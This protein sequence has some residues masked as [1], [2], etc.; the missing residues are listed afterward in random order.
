MKF[1]NNKVKKIIKWWLI[2][3]LSAIILFVLF[4]LIASNITVNNQNTGDKTELIYIQDNGRHID[5]ITKENDSCYIGYGWG[6]EVFY[7]NV[8]TW[9]DLTVKVVCQA[10]F[11]KPKSLM[12]I[13]YHKNINNN[14]KE[15]KV[16]KE[17]LSNLNDIIASS[18]KTIDG[19]LVFRSKGYTDSDV[20]YEANG[21]YTIFKTCN[22]WANNV[23]KKSG[24]KALYW[25]PFSSDISE[26]YK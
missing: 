26:L 25:T 12:H 20:F 5:I 15:I 13:T 11:T 10:L 14:W 16:T 22:T 18:F 3:K 17:Q 6:S 23:L 9:D 21:N 8:P 19:N 1:I 4:Y 2:I 7:L 24:I